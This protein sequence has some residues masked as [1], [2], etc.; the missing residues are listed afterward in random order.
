VGE[1]RT[2]TSVL[3]LH[4]TT[5]QTLELRQ[6]SEREF[7]PQEMGVERG[8]TIPTLDSTTLDSTTP[9]NK[10][11]LQLNGLRNPNF[12]GRNTTLQELHHIITLRRPNTLT[13]NVLVIHGTG[14]VGKTQVVQEYA[15][16]HQED[17]SWIFVIEAHS[18]DALMTSYCNVAQQIVEHS[19]E[20]ACELSDLLDTSS[21]NIA[22]RSPATESLTL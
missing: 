22:N 2:S 20:V 4:Q 8:S 9:F 11:P 19:K 10:A 7:H 15:Y 13:P 14:R 3:T 5:L 6:Q 21:R 17:F 12:T 18:F 1:L 16:R